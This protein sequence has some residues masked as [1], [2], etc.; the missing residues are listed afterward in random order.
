[1]EQVLRRY[2]VRLLLFIILLPAA[3]GMFT[4]NDQFQSTVDVLPSHQ[5]SS[6]AV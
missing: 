2:S 5:T 1:M 6:Q 4:A 3:S